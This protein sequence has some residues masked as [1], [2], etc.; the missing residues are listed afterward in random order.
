MTNVD[1]RTPRRFGAWVAAVAAVLALLAGGL[2]WWML[3][4]RE[5]PPASAASPTAVHTPASDTPTPAPSPTPIGFPAD[6]AVYSV[7]ELPQV[8]VYAV[9]PALPVD[10][11]PFGAFTGELVR[12]AAERVPVW[13]DPTAE[14]VAA[15]PRDHMFDGTTVPVVERQEH[16][17][18][19]LLTGRSSTPSLGNPAQIT[20][21]LRVSDVEFSTTDTS[22]EVD[23]AGRTVDI[24]RRDGGHE[25]IAT[26]FGFGAQGTPTPTGRAFVM[27]VRTEPSFAYTRGHPL[28]YLSVQSPTLDGFAGAPVAVTAFHYHDARSGAI[29]NGCLRV[30]PEAIQR[31]AQLPPGTPVVIR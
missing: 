26:D 22:V 23:L 30:A 16:W 2:F 15:L 21:W 29:S 9:I 3:G 8:D 11:A 24:V 6:T 31:L 12:A 13:P 20:G 4:P 7:A 1:D 28:V 25:R 27:M 19:V 17:V 14:P 18:R 10:S 5:E